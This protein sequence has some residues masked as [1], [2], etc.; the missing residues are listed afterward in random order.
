METK[1]FASANSYNG[2]YSLFGSI[3]DS[4]RFDNVFVLKGGPGTGKS[5]LMKKIADFTKSKGGQTKLYYCSSDINSLDGVIINIDEKH[6][7]IIDGT[8]PHERDAVLVGAI[9][10]IINLGDSIDRDWIRGHRDNIIS[11]SKQKSEAHKAA[12][13]YLRIAGACYEEIYKKNLSGFS[14]YSASKFISDLPINTNFIEQKTEKTFISSFSKVG[15]KTFQISNDSYN[16]SIKICGDK[17]NIKIL[18]EYISDIFEYGDA[19]IFPSPLNPDLPEACII[20]GCL[21][22]GT[23]ND[24]SSTDSAKFF[25]TSKT[26]KE[27]VRLMKT[28]HDDALEEASRWLS[29]AADI[30]FRLEDIYTKCMNFEN[31]EAIFDKICKK[32][33]KVCEC[34]N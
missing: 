23:D 2:F 3:F 29:I 16:K 19:K 25:D 26:D 33:L 1:Y 22:I 28:I 11:L 4:R 14:A 5:T 30:H 24:S 34:D 6:F 12:Y 17:T 18:L 10:E 32:I 31:N 13:S 21:I 27:E 20:D 9:D 15:Y 8:A 7:A